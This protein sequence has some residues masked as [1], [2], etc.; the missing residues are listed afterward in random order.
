MKNTIETWNTTYDRIKDVEVNA[1]RDVK[2]DEIGVCLIILSYVQNK[3]VEK[4]VTLN[5][6]K[7]KWLKIVKQVQEHIDTL[8]EP[9]KKNMRRFLTC[10]EVDEI[11]AEE[12]K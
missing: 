3:H 2:N 1:W 6:T 12:E 4:S 7:K 5:F 11:L 9:V 8:E 10:D